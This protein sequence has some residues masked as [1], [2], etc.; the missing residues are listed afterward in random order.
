M[1][2]AVQENE[3]F[4]GD[5]TT[6]T[7]SAF[8]LFR[9]YPPRPICCEKWKFIPFF[10]EFHQFTGMIKAPSFRKPSLNAAALLLTLPIVANM[11]S[12]VTAEFFFNLLILVTL[13]WT[14]FKSHGLNRK[15]L[16][17]RSS[18]DFLWIALIGI[19]VLGYAVNGTFGNDQ[20]HDLLQFLWIL[21]LYCYSR[22]L[23]IA[24]F[25][26]TSLRLFSV[27]IVL[28]CITLIYQFYKFPPEYPEVWGYPNRLRGTFSN[29]NFLA[30]SYYLIYLIIAGLILSHFMAK[31]F[32]DVVWLGSAF[33]AMTPVLVLTFNRSIWLASA[34]A[35]PLLAAMWKR[36]IAAITVCVILLLGGGLYVGNIAGFATRI[37]SA[38]N[39]STT[40]DISRINLW[41]ANFHIFKE[42]PILGIGYY[43]NTRNIQKYYD[44]LGI[45]EKTEKS[46]AHSE[47]LSFLA[48]TGI[49]GASLYLSLFVFF[50]SLALK[51]LKHV[52]VN[53][54]IKRGLLM[55][56]FI[57]Q[58]A[59][60]IA[61]IA[62]NNFEIHSA[63]HFLVTT[64]ALT[65]WLAYS[66]KSLSSKTDVA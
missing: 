15:N 56:A 8:S 26:K 13:I 55:G 16:I 44:E 40:G 27:F 66:Y 25:P 33:L 39:P 60:L 54:P 20:L 32:K 36:S 45:K 21:G 50:S 19:I 17:T 2:S 11:F 9:D 59:F 42:N 53:E 43:N 10:E 62:D 46:H 23:Q 5:K 28:T 29:T 52:P 63:R 24:I 47:I 14:A 7:L 41:K 22:Q 57:I 6:Y 49:L 31:K 30:H 58:P 35:F 48:G 3:L 34:V 12:R 38:L 64:W 4:V 18:F 61:G 65:L 37:E 51:T 1:R